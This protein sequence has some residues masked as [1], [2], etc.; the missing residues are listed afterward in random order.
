[1]SGGS[2]NYLYRAAETDDVTQLVQQIG[3]LQA[4]KDRL[5]ELAAQEVPGAA[6]GAYMTRVAL[7][8][9]RRSQHTARRLV[10]IWH[11][12]EWLDSG[13]WDMAQA[14]EALARYEG[15]PRGS[16]N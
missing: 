5:D 16:R 11:A 6:Y 9:L 4:M 2:Y 10:E 8:H 14:R 1:M 3:D 13:D 7:A 12:V 15:A